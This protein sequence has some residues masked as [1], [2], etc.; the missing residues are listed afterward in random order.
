MSNKEIN[1]EETLIDKFGDFAKE[2]L[3]LD[4]TNSLQL[5][6]LKSCAI[7]YGIAFVFIIFSIV[8]MVYFSADGNSLTTKTY[9][10]FLY[11][12]FPLLIGIVIAMPMFS[13]KSNN[14]MIIAG[15]ATISIV[16]ISLGYYYSTST[17]TSFLIANYAINVIIGLII[18][19]GLAI[20]Y[21]MF[22]NHLQKSSGLSGLFITFIFYIP[23][24]VSDFIKYLAGQYQ[25][26]PN[27]IFILFLVEIL[28]IASYLYAP[29]LLQ[30]LLKNN[31]NTVVILPDAKFLD[32]PRVF[33]AGN[34]PFTT[35][36]MSAT[37]PN[38]YRTNYGLSMWIYLNQLPMSN[39]AYAENTNIFSYTNNEPNATVRGGKPG[40]DYCNKCDAD[41]QNNTKARLIVYFSNV[42][43][44]SQYKISVPNQKWNNFVFNYRDNIVDLFVNGQLERSY[45]FTDDIPV[46]SAYDNLYVGSKDGLSGAI[47]NITYSTLPF[48][49]GQISNTYNLLMYKNPPV[50]YV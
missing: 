7:Q 25:I 2:R 5:E 26:T 38:T 35:A 30:K 6:T 29:S 13:A 27:I 39:K 20:F 37:I 19:V 8:M 46:Y 11:I 22:V 41:S 12:M 16:L 44:K 4:I 9:A 49:K 45:E 14:S 48:T 17:A 18:I 47:C 15:I 31:D 36:P 32:A 3:H 50:N 33:P 23:C 10:Y 24:L 43:E 21:N 42:S 34:F 40:I 1:D 28:L